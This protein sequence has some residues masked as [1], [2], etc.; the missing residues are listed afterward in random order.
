MCKCYKNTFVG[1]FQSSVV[2]F[3]LENLNKIKLNK[4]R[5][6]VKNTRNVGRMELKL[7]ISGSSRKTYV[8]FLGWWTSGTSHK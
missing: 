1:P 4:A 7:L 6:F 5:N 8:G 2:K 3:F